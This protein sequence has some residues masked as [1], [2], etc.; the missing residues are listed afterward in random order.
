MDIILQPWHW[1][2][3]GILLILSELI[4][5]AFAALWFGLAALLVA[6]LSWIFPGLGTTAQIVIWLF[7]SVA[8]TLAWFKWIKP[9]SVDKT[10]AGL[11]REATIGQVGMVIQLKATPEQIVVRFPMPLLGDDEWHCRTTLPVQVGDRVQIV[12]ILGNEM[13]VKPYSSTRI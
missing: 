13:L 3:L 4:L 5:P 11:A 6:L 2:I 1:C 9:L 7:A 10:Q 8:C 12:D